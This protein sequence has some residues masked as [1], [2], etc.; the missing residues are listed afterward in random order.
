MNEGIASLRLCLISCEEDLQ[1]ILAVGIEDADWYQI[2]SDCY[3]LLD[4]IDEDERTPGEVSQRQ[5]LLKLTVEY[6]EKH[7]RFGN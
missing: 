6:E 4:S 2:A 7:Y 3:V 5:R 1:H